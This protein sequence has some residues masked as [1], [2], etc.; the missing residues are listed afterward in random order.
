MSEQETPAL[1]SK[2]AEKIRDYL[3]AH[4]DFFQHYPEPL[5]QLVLEHPSGRAVS[6][7][8]RQVT[9]LRDKNSK[10]SREI[11][12]LLKNARANHDIFQKTSDLTIE[13]LHTDGLHDFLTTLVTTL[14][15]DFSIAHIM[16]R[17]A[18][19]PSEASER[20]EPVSGQ[21]RQVLKNLLNKSKP[22]CGLLRRNQVQYLFGE[23]AT[24][25]R[26]SALIPLGLHAELGF[27]V[28][29]STDNEQFH[30]SMDTLFLRFLSRVLSSL[31]PKYFCQTPLAD[32]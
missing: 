25:I 8:E 17:L 18:G 20:F 24:E 27:L 12:D 15:R 32:A 28:I 1:D 21:D 10:L 29:G 7:I 4:P 3:L 2:E 16:I 30:A 26:S 14:R 13:L 31:L 19:E 5:E 23:H 6:L 22:I 11:D 9:A